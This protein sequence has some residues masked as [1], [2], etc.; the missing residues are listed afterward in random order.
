VGTVGFNWQLFVI[1]CSVV[2]SFSTDCGLCML[3]N[4]QS[5]RV[6]VASRDRIMSLYIIV[7]TLR[8]LWSALNYTLAVVNFIS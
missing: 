8:M 4:L 6:C 2:L 3:T 5:L 7:A 1:F